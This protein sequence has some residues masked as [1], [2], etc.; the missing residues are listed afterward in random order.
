MAIPGMLS[1]VSLKLCSMDLQ[2]FLWF[3]ANIYLSK[4]KSSCYT[5]VER[6]INCKNV[7]NAKTNVIFQKKSEELILMAD[8]F[9]RLK[10]KRDT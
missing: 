5:R 8:N 9:N 6:V 3:V 7:V 4:L 2:Y 1:V 10:G